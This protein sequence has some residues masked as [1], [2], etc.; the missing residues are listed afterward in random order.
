MLAGCK[1]SFEQLV[2]YRSRP[3]PERALWVIAETLDLCRLF[4]AIVPKNRVRF[5]FLSIPPVSRAVSELCVPHE[6]R[7][8]VPAQM[9]G[10][11]QVVGRFE[12]RLDKERFEPLRVHV[13]CR[14]RVQTDHADRG[15]R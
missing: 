15:E 3:R 11:N 14:L 1:S 4:H 13:V 5:F 12:A 8:R 6:C 9:H 2:H 10:M 7:V